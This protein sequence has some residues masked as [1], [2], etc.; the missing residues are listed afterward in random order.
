MTGLTLV[1][2]PTYAAGQILPFHFY[3]TKDGLLSNRV[4]GISQDP[5]GY[6]WVSTFEGLS[7]FDGQ[8]FRNFTATESLSTSVVWSVCASAAAP[9][10]IWL[11]TDEGGLTRYRDGAFSTLHLSDSLRRDVITSINE[12]PDGTLWCVTNASLDIVRGNSVTSVILRTPSANFSNIVRT[13]D[14][15]HWLAIDRTLYSFS[16]QGRQTGA[17]VLPAGD[18]AALD[19][20]FADADTTLWA[21]GTD[22]SMFHCRGGGILGSRRVVSRDALIACLDDRQGTLWIGTASALLK[23]TKSRFDTDPFQRLSS[24]SGMPVDMVSPVLMDREGDLWGATW[25]HGLFNLSEQSTVLIPAPPGAI[26]RSLVIDASDHGWLLL[27][28]SIVEIW[29]DASGWRSVTHSLT[30]AGANPSA[31]FLIPS[32]EEMVVSYQDGRIGRYR[33]V[34]HPPEASEFRLVGWFRKAAGLPGPGRFPVAVDSLGRIWYSL[35][36]DYAA[37]VDLRNGTVDKVLHQP[38]DMPFSGIRAMAVDRRGNLWIGGFDHGLGMLPRGDWSHESIRVFTKKDGLPDE[39]IRTLLADDDL[40]LWI[41]TRR[42]GLA[43]YRD[44][45]F[46]TFTQRNG[47]LSN[48]IWS[49]RQTKD[50]RLWLGTSLGLMWI[51]P[52]RPGEMSVINETRGYEC[53]RCEIDGR[54]RVWAMT[55]EGVF[56]CDYLRRSPIATPPP[57]YISRI[58]VNGSVVDMGTRHGF[59]HDEN[60]FTIEYIGI[61]LRNEG[62]VRYH[63]LL[64]GTDR[65]WSPLTNQRQV[66]YATLSPGT[67]TILVEAF[68]ADG[69]K[70]AAPASY[71]F[72][73]G[74]PYWRR[75]WFIM[76]SNAAVL[77]AIAYAATRRVRILRKERRLQQEFS[78]RLLSSQ[79]DERKRI[80]AELHDS[81]GQDLTLIKNHSVL[82][83]N[84]IAENSDAR[85]H[86]Q[87][88]DSISSETMRAVRRISHNLRPYQIDRL[89]ITRALRSLIEGFAQSSPSACT[90]D[91][92]PIDGLLGSNGEINV[93]RIAQEILTNVARHAKATSV[94][95]RIRREE[96]ASILLL[97]T[98]NGQGLPDGAGARGSRQPGLGLESIAER[99]QILGGT[100]TISSTP[101]LGTRI[102][103][104][105]PYDEQRRNDQPSDR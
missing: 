104:R 9:G 56:V 38:E 16:P 29:S 49:V 99:V 45:R 14:G 35:E 66:T 17:M 101:Q 77:G 81:I 57:A 86:L 47:L 85:A 11:G 27:D 34:P 21:C 73:V 78:R 51:N 88:I 58:S 96:N 94:D 48:T 60:N 70:S 89:G 83:L 33:I 68:N 103:I 4:T 36:S 91:I 90:V 64:E 65:D 75:W 5:S 22:G 80:A 62:D 69:V 54:G 12:D 71:T 59:P 10:T 98:D 15:A 7:V 19:N 40:N 8:T 84:T 37:L 53:E 18:S 43:V 13:P 72:T 100:Y 105:I 50:K 31:Q 67:Y 82:A 102:Q 20:L 92:D 42:G 52:A 95:V 61:S 24:S 46:T 26:L 79:E 41:G 74:L 25:N 39:G 97:F 2:F 28:R 1:L 32:G 63:Y 93:Y 3:T 44:G 23:I 76:L 30:S 6:L 55:S 87:E